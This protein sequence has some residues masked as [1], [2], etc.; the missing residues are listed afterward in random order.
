MKIGI[1]GGYGHASV[2]HYPDAT[3]VWSLDGYDDAVSRRAGSAT[4]YP[5]LEAMIAAESPDLVYIGTVYG[6]NGMLA[7]RAL[8]QGVSVV[9]EK[10]M[11]ADET[12]LERLRE[13]TA[14]GERRIISEFA[15]RWSPAFVKAWELITGGVI[16]EPVLVQAQKSYKFGASRPE[17]YKTRELFGGIIPWVAMHAID[18]AS[19]CTGLPYEGVTS[20]SHGNRCFPDYPEMED[21]AALMLRLQGDVPCVITADFLRPSGASTHGDD[22]LRVTGT[23]GVAE[24]I[25]ARL[26]LTT[27]DGEEQWELPVN[28]ASQK[29]CAVD[30]VESA[31][32]RPAAISMDD[33]F[34]ITAIALKARELADRKH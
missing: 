9:C 11:A 25:G 7:V 23:H 28:E 6:Q 24:V 26:T 27:A 20:A 29:R 1:V 12:T 4:V 17:F 33:S 31:M 30:L 16:G 5:S 13:L 15:M 21:Y 18:F 14:T 34:R 8:E 3:L 19:W 32:G 10:P 22:R 2:A